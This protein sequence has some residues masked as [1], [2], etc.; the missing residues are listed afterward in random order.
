[1]A[2]GFKCPSPPVIIPSTICFIKPE[3]ISW[4]YSSILKDQDKPKASS[5]KLHLDVCRGSIKKKTTV[6]RAN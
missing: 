2:K 5:S 6:E 4:F 1:V 3:D